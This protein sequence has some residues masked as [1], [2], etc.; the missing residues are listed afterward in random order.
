MSKLKTKNGVYATNGALEQAGLAVAFNKE[1]FLFKVNKINSESWQDAVKALIKNTHTVLAQ[2]NNDNETYPLTMLNAGGILT[3]VTDDDVRAPLGMMMLNEKNGLQLGFGKVELRDLDNTLHGLQRTLDNELKEILSKL[4]SESENKDAFIAKIKSDEVYAQFANLENKLAEADSVVSN[5][6]ANISINQNTQE[7]ASS[8][9]RPPLKP[10]TVKAIKTAAIRE[11]TEE[12][13]FKIK[14]ESLNIDR[15]CAGDAINRGESTEYVRSVL[16]IKDQDKAKF[17][18]KEFNNDFESTTFVVT[19]AVSQDEFQNLTA[20]ET[21][22]LVQPKDVEIKVT[23]LDKATLQTSMIG[24]PPV[25]G[26]GNQFTI[27]FACNKLFGKNATFVP[28][29]LS[30]PTSSSA[31]MFSTSPVSQVPSTGTSTNT[32]TVNNK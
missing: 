29:E 32:S 18:A 7:Q 4:L 15:Y 23:S 28:T 21:C 31:A 27:A 13:Q 20:A 30:S 6:L 19:C 8:F 2:Y 14:G 3:F 1:N 25:L 24:Y 5:V 11:I 10:Y 26:G 22:K 16:A 12:V 9:G 17:S